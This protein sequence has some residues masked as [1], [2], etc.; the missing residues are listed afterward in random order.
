[1]RPQRITVAAKRIGDLRSDVVEVADGAEQRGAV[2]VEQLGRRNEVFGAARQ[3][4]AAALED[5][6]AG[7][8]EADRRRQRR[9]EIGLLL[10]DG[11]G[12]DHCVA[13]E[14]P[15]VR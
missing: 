9:I 5:V 7:V 12:G 4:R 13:Q 8:A 15:Q 6:G 3:I 14:S 11:A 2:F 10:V 1:M